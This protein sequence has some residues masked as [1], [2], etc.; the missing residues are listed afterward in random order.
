[1]TTETTPTASAMTDERAAAEARRIITEFATSYR[2]TTPLPPVGT[3]PPVA[4]PGVPPMSARTTETLRAVMYVSAATVPP[5]LI[6]I[7]VLVA[8]DYAN[9]AVIAWICAAPAALAVPILALAR[10]M[11][12]AGE[13]APTEHHH[14]YTGPVRQQTVNSHSR[15]LGKTTNNL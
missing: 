6:A 14:H 4:Q 13:A 1:M 2:D 9:P 11:R 10:L 8:S 7:G 15:W 5:G 3:A 12:R